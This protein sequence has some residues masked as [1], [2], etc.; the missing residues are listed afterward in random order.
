MAFE[1]PRPRPAWGWEGGAGVHTGV[2][3][4]TTTTPPA[5][6]W[7]GRS[8]GHVSGHGTNLVAW[9]RTWRC[10]PG[11]TSAAAPAGAVCDSAVSGR[12]AGATH[13]VTPESCRGLGR[14]GAAPAGGVR[15]SAV[16][17]RHAGATRPVTPES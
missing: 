1:G 15:D 14:V 12:H 16:S 3:C 11:A 4:A 17:G 9:R 8:P 7:V 2:V 5:P 6:G 13:P 10:C